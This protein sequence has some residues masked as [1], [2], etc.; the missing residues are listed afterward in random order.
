MHYTVIN[1]VLQL[2]LKGSKI[3]FHFNNKKLYRV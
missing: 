3:N 2:H 1:T